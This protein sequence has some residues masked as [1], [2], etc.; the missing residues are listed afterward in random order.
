[1]MAIMMERAASE[2]KM[3]ASLILC[4]SKQEVALHLN[5]LILECATKAIAERGAFSVALSGGS[6]ISFLAQL[7]RETN[8]PGVDDS[9]SHESDGGDKPQFDKWHVILA[10]ERLVPLSDPESN[11]GALQAQ[12]LST[13]AI[14][15]SQIHGASQDLIRDGSPEDVALDYEEKVKSVLALT[16]GSLDLAVLG[17]GPDGHTCSL[18]PGHD[19]VLKGS[20]DSESARRWVAAVVDSPKPPP[21]RIT[22]TLSTLNQ[23]TRRIIFCGTGSSKLPILELVFSSV[24]DPSGNGSRSSATRILDATMTDPPPFPCAMVR[25]VAGGDSRNVTWIVDAEAMDGIPVA[26]VKQGPTV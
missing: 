3:K 6:L 18:F 20:D 24:F 16:G 13:V 7:D 1:M 4:P 26:A 5:D 14:P 22:L 11:L 23:R 8:H 21:R 9:N 2:T 17:F 10:D 25:P 19:L 12:A 15:R